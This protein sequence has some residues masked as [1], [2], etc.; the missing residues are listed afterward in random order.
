MLGDLEAGGARELIG[1]AG[2]ESGKGKSGIEAR[3][4]AP[5][6]ALSCH[7]RCGRRRCQRPDQL[8]GDDERHA[9]GPAERCCGQLFDARDKSLLDPLQDKPVGRD[10]HQAVAG[11]L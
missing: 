4:L 9:R 5:P 10:Q 7:R 11:M 1:L 3:L 6:A 8:F 2:D